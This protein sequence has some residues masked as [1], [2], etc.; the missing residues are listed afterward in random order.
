MLIRILSGRECPLFIYNVL[1]REMDV[2]TYDPPLAAL[3]AQA[4]ASRS[5]TEWKADK[6][7]NQFDEFKSVVNSADFQVFVPGFFDHYNPAAKGKIQQAVNETSGQ[8]LFFTT[9]LRNCE[10]TMQ[11]DN[12]LVHEAYINLK[13]GNRESARRYAERALLAVDDTETRV[14]ASFIL[15]QTT[16][17]PKEKRDLLETVLA[18]DRTHAEA[19]RAL[20]ILDGKLK[21]EDIVDADNLPAQSTEQARADRFTCPKCGARRVFAPDGHSLLCENCG[22][23]DSLVMDGEAGESD[24]FTAMATAKGHRKPVAMQVFHCQGCGAE[25]ILALGVISATCAYCDSPHVVRLEESRELLE[26]DGIIPHALTQKQAIE[27]LV[28]WVD[29]YEI[30][31]EQKVDLPRGIYMPLW[32]FDI[33]GGIECPQGHNIPDGDGGVSPGATRGAR[34]RAISPVH[35]RFVDPR[36]QKDCRP[37]RL[38]PFDL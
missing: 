31:P 32:T 29:L 33:G 25:F 15:S 19:R 38:H 3:K 34:A 9:Q 11:R 21:P 1:P 14:K 26:P 23:N 16:D 18:Y 7:Y 4:L 5:I 27:K 30:K 2:V 22:Y 20:A 13:A 24:F 6:R 17:D 10:T 37:A 8:Y 35:Q 12:E 28:L 36:Q